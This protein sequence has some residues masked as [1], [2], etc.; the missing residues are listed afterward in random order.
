MPEVITAGET[1][2]VM[3]PKE[4]GPLRYVP[5]YR[6]RMAGAE[7]NLAAGLCRLGHSAGWISRLGDD[8]MGRFVLNSVRAEGVDT[9]AVKTDGAHRTGLMLKETGSGETRVYYYRENS[10]ASHLSPEDLEEEYLHSARIIHLTGI[11]PVL[12]GSCEDTVRTMAEFARRYGI[13][14]SFDPNIRKKLWGERDYRPLMREL[15]FSSQIALL[16]LDEAEQLLWTRK[17]EEIVGILREKGVRWIA[18][19]DGSR[20]AWAADQEGLE[21][22]EPYPCRPVDPIGAGDAFDAAFLAGILEGRDLRTCGQMG[23]IAGAMATETSGDIE[24]CPSKEQIM[25]KLEKKQEIF[26]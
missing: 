19:K 24:G 20:G 2:A 22:I 9:C 18:L 15:L 8:E 26:R 3:A 12:S 14:L 25:A 17:P 21:R 13:L 7:S 11:T 4:A 6:L 5:D 10:A 1:M 16:G 23:G